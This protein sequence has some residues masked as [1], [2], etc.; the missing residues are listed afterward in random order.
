M[1]TKKLNSVFLTL[2]ILCGFTPVVRKAWA[3]HEIRPVVLVHGINDDGGGWD[4]TAVL[5]ALVAARGE[6]NVY[7]PTF[8]VTNL[9]LCIHGKPIENLAQDLWLYLL[10]YDLTGVDMVAHS[11][12]GL[13]CREYIEYFNGYIDVHT[14]TMLSTPNWGTDLT[15]LA[16]LW[17]CVANDTEV[18]Q[19]MP[20]SSFLNYLNYYDDVGS[21]MK[22]LSFINCY[23]K[24]VY[25]DDPNINPCCSSPCSQARAAYLCSVP[26]LVY[27]G[28]CINRVFPN[29]GMPPP[30][31]MISEWFSY[32]HGFTRNDPEVVTSLI[33]IVFVPMEQ[34][35]LKGVGA[36]Q[37]MSTRYSF[38]VTNENEIGWINQVEVRCNDPNAII[39]SPPQWTGIYDNGVIR[40]TCNNP[41]FYI[42]PEEPDNTFSYISEIPLPS[43]TWRLSVAGVT[44]TLEQ[45]ISPSGRLGEGW[46]IISVPLLPT[47]AEAPSV[48][49]DIWPVV[50]NLYCYGP[51]EGYLSYPEFTYMQHGVGYY[52][53]LSAEGVETL[54]GTNPGTD[55]E[56]A[57]AEGWNLIGHPFVYPVQL[58]LCQVSDGNETKSI[59]E[60]QD[61]GW[62]IARIYFYDDNAYKMV[63]ITQPRDDDSL[64]PWYGYWILAR[65]PALTLTVPSS[66]GAMSAGTEDEKETADDIKTSQVGGNFN[67]CIYLDANNCTSW[68]FHAGIEAGASDGNDLLDMPAP[69]LPPPGLTEVRFTTEVA[70]QGPQMYDYRPPPPT[71]SSKI[72]NATAYS[73]NFQSGQC[74]QVTMTWDLTMVDRYCYELVNLDSGEIIALTAGGEYTFEICEEEALPFELTATLRDYLADLDCDGDVD[75]LDLGKFVMHWLEGGCG[76]SNGWCAGTMLGSDETVNMDDF[77]KFAENWLAGAEP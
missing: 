61:A 29:E 12:G 16:F 13:I 65:Q 73:V 64:R 9:P 5:R 35:T 50:E 68:D 10:L 8:S 59:Q 33:D 62:I 3:V 39:E 57:L 19:M 51:N 74:K 1:E 18:L 2:L 30:K 48:L 53:R 7:I 66:G 31:V 67:L 77:A 17:P 23:D 43:L 41:A 60:A 26:P 4:N 49:D 32:H 54:S 38:E 25:I 70:P 55:M 20:N 46:N 45:T 27:D 47:D 63:N 37:T 42:A 72:W 22:I 24:I 15:Y 71:G 21:Y 44:A 69:P 75:L 34:Q 56:I 58:E 52:L 28:Q 76:P 14:L 6:D 40:W 11:M 36:A